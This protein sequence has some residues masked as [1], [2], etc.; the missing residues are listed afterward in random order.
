MIALSV[1]L[2]LR[3]KLVVLGVPFNEDLGPCA[4]VACTV[5]WPLAD[6]GKRLV[7]DAPLLLAWAYRPV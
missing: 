7:V 6:G 3:T 1:E 4:N 2:A 5:C